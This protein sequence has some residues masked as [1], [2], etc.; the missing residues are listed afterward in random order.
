MNQQCGSSCNSET[1]KCYKFNQFYHGNPMNPS[2][3]NYNVGREYI[4]PNPGKKCNKGNQNKLVGCHHQSPNIGVHNLCPFQEGKPVEE[5]VGSGSNSGYLGVHPGGFVNRCCI[6]TSGTKN[7]TNYDLEALGYKVNKPT[8]TNLDP[9][10]MNIFG[11]P[12][13]SCQW[14]PTCTC[15][16]NCKCGPGCTCGQENKE[17]KYNLGDYA[18]DLDNSGNIQPKKSSGDDKNDENFLNRLF[19]FVSN[20]DQK[21]GAETTDKVTGE[22]CKGTEDFS[23]KYECKEKD[24]CTVPVRVTTGD[25]NQNMKSVCQDKVRCG[26]GE[27]G[28]QYGCCKSCNNKSAQIFSHPYNSSRE[29]GLFTQ[30]EE[31][32]SY[33][34]DLTQPSIGGRQVWVHSHRQKIPDILVCDTVQNTDKCFNCR[35][36]CWGKKCM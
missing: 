14:N 36:P 31:V 34:F 6:H 21:G 2:C 30:P 15:G 5:Q 16:V 1:N 12:G 20:Q 11:Y 24:G 9:E 10:L 4:C 13:Y 26:N 27:L 7:P 29:Y 32:P 35:Q 17:T 25:S 19:G 22:S 28:Q 33:Y 18:V 3:F 23:F 8:P